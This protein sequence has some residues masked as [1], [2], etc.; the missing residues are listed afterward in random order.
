MRYLLVLLSIFLVGCKN[1]T[2][3]FNIPS[4]TISDY[5]VNSSQLTDS[6][7]YDKILGALVGSAIG[8]AMGAS[9]EMWHRKD[10][11]L[12]YGYITGLTPALREQSPEGTWEHNLLA[13]ATT[14]DTR[15]KSLMVHYFKT[16]NNSITPE[17]F[18]DHIIEYY[19]SLTKSLANKD[20]Q[21]STDALDTQIEKID[22][23]KEWAQ[24]AMAYKKDQDSYLKAQN[25]FYGGEMSCAGQLYSPMLGLISKSTVDAYE[26]AYSLSL[27]DIGYAKDITALVSTMTFIATRTQNLDSILNA[28]KFVDPI[29]YSDSRLVSRIPTT[30]LNNAQINVRRINEL[31]IDSLLLNDTLIYKAPKGFKGSKIDWI[32]QEML[33]RILEK[34]ER[35]IAF[36][37]AEIWQILITALEFGQGDFEK[38]MQFI[39]N[40]GRD[41]DTVAAVAG[42]ILGAKIGFKAL[43][44]HLK[45]TIIKVNR[46]NM[47]IDLEVLAQEMTTIKD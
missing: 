20:I 28:P 31:V 38:T 44:P 23:I 40:Y 16:H 34:D 3:K 9:T 17:N 37:S 25:R 19:S 7:Y 10:I 24:V 4:P 21:V 8:D 42:M 5:E 35:S 33:Y 6:I 29:G 36:H 27:F 12:S 13:G 47:G 18:V 2:D 43:P 30:L 11:Q 1:D 39:V 26:K 46:E 45:E 15:W 32:R 41:N 14:D 22:W